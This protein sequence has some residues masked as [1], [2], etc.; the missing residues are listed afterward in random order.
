[1]TKENASPALPGGDGGSG[2]DRFGESTRRL[3]TAERYLDI[4]EVILVALNP[5]GEITFVNPKGCA[6]LGYERAELLGRNWFETCLPEEGRD[7]V[8]AVFRKLMAGELDPGEYH[9]NPIVTRGGERREI[10]WHNSFLR[11]D[12]GAIVESM[13][14]GLDITERKQAHDALIESEAKHRQIL[15]HL[16][17]AVV[18]HAADTG[19]LMANRRAAELLGLDAGTMEGRKVT[20]PAW[21]FIRQDGTR[22]SLEEYPISRVVARQAPVEDL[23]V[24][25]VW[26]G[27]GTTVWALAN[28]YPMFDE[29]GALEQVIV[30]FIDITSL[31]KA[32]EERRHLAAQVLHAQKLESLGVLA[33]GLAH[34]F[35]NLLMGIMGNAEL[36]VSEVPEGSVVGEFLGAIEATCVR[37]SDLCRQMLAYSGKGRFQ[38][39]LIDLTE[40]VFELGHLLEVSVSKKVNLVY[41]LAVDLPCVEADLAQ[42]EQVVMNLITNASE[43]QDDEGGTVRVSTGVAAGNDAN[44]AGMVHADALS[45]GPCIFLQVSDDG[46]GMSAETLSRIFD[47][48][49]STKFTGRGLGLA[50]V[51][52][53]VR[54]HS[55]AIGIDS[56]P[57]KGTTVRVLLPV[58]EKEVRACSGKAP[59]QREA[60]QGGTVLLVDDERVVRETTARILRRLGY[61]VITAGDGIE[62][63]EAC[64][65]HGD[66]VVCVVLDLTMP[67]MGGQQALNEIR[68]VRSDLPVILS[69]GYNEQEVTQEFTGCGLA[70][71]LQKPYKV[72]Q[73]AEKLRS[74]I[75]GN[76]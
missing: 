30:S 10:A 5:K 3:A 13:S 41:E 73:L 6:V 28:A 71:F 48:F 7:A 53:I 75:A 57:G 18:V 70:G 17:A 31:R 67:R 19:I 50:A 64:K 24:G 44:L 2:N 1:M 9:E 22:M 8:L 52:G 11:D 55:G 59:E 69:S 72:A 65:T 15:D 47:P 34:D 56:E 39:E 49:F 66:T 46:C 35:N 33:G 61:D 29:G 68:K 27:P 37:A 54:G 51:L 32:E 38:I 16:Q 14:S 36:A 12:N 40:L 60:P 63:I 4:T 23:V 76:P 25:I 74:A 26:D 62:A 42:M 21:H 45:E 20:D 58:S 43:A